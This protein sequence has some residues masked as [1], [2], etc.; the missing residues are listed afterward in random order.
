MRNAVFQR[1]RYR[2]L[3]LIPLELSAQVNVKF[4]KAIGRLLLTFG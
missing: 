3:F 4:A 1:N 2:T